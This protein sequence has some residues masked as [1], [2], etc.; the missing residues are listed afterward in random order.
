MQKGAVYA[1]LKRLHAHLEEKLDPLDGSYSCFGDGSG[2]P[3]SQEVLGEGNSG[4]G[5][6]RGAVRMSRGFACRVEMADSKLED[7]GFK[8]A[9][10]K[11]SRELRL[12]LLRLIGWPRQKWAGRVMSFDSDLVVF[13]ITQDH[14]GYTNLFFFFFK[15][16]HNSVIPTQLWDVRFH[17]VP[18][19]MSGTNVKKRWGPKGYCG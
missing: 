12:R 10:R 3:T 11:R 13:L 14:N 16:R 8:K 9:V 2:N 17:L 15:Y 1:A 5:H 6:L 18:A 4:V 19:L 7:G